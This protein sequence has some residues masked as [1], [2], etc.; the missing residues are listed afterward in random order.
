MSAPL[1]T[2][3]PDGRTELLQAHV[4]RLGEEVDTRITLV[5]M[6]GEVGRVKV[7]VVELN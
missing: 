4:R 1:A 6:N 7:S 5:A 3:L 2:V